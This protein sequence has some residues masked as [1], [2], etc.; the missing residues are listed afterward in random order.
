MKT[1]KLGGAK[2]KK[3]SYEEMLDRDNRIQRAQILAISIKETISDGEFFN[4]IDELKLGK[5]SKEDT[6]KIIDTLM[7]IAKSA[8]TIDDELDVVIKTYL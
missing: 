5:S 6:K 3:L 1:F 4:K 2:V 8:K 7:W